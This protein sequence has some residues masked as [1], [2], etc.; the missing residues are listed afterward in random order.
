MADTNDRSMWSAFQQHLDHPTTRITTKVKDLIL[1]LSGGTAGINND[2]LTSPATIKKKKKKD[3]DTPDTCLWN[4]TTS[5]ALPSV[6]HVG[7][8]T[9]LG[10][11]VTLYVLNQ[12]HNLPKPLSAIV[13]KVLFWPTLP[14]TVSRR[15]GKWA[16]P[17][18]DTVVLGGAPFGFVNYPE[19]LYNDYGV[20]G[21]INMC[22]E[23]GGPAKKYEQMGITQLRLPTTDHFVPSVED[24]Q[25]AVEFIQEYEARGER[26]YVHCRAGH[27]R[28]AAAVFA[29]LLSKDPMEVDLEELNNELCQLRCVRKTLWKQQNILDFHASLQKQTTRGGGGGGG[30]RRPMFGLDQMNKKEKQ[31]MEQDNDDDLSFHTATGRTEGKF[32]DDYQLNDEDFFSDAGD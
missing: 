19:R 18:D 15:I 30:G 25:S 29:W 8:K 2:I 3:D 31:D 13:S 27:G 23:Y 4:A 21:V 22:E 16:T 17:I 10:I 1:S 7:L 12:T 5:A 28:S 6:V 11:T 9:L 24:L 26:V 20:R 32:E 14:I